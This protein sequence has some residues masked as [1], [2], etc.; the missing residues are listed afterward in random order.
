MAWRKGDS[1]RSAGD[2]IRS[3]GDRANGGCEVTAVRPAA[4]HRAG[5]PGRGFGVWGGSGVVP[6]DRGV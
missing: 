1:I 5:A 3:A 2:S 4:A 6:Y